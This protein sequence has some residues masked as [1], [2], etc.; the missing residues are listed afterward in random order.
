MLKTRTSFEVIRVAGDEQLITM[1]M[2]VQLLQVI[3]ITTTTIT[4]T[5]LA[6]GELFVKMPLTI[7]PIVQD[8]ITGR[9]IVVQRLYPIDPAFFS[10]LTPADIVMTLNNVQ[11]LFVMRST[12]AGALV[13]GAAAKSA[14][15]KATQ[16]N[17]NPSNKW[18]VNI[19]LT[20]IESVLNASEI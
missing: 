14:G 10:R 8:A 2:A 16:L 4:I 13:L 20:D 3:L 1:R 19:S 18:T 9:N 15:L 5:N 12:I 11:L 17:Y 7:N 6:Y